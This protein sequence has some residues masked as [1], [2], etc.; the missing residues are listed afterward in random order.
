MVG[1]KYITA[2]FVH[3]KFVF[4]MIIDLNKQVVIQGFDKICPNVPSVSENEAGRP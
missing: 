1:E 3:P 4:N 2:L